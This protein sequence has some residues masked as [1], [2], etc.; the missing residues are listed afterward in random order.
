M[1]PEGPHQPLKLERLD[2]GVA[3]VMRAQ[4]RNQHIL[5]LNVHITKDAKD[6]YCH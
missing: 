4:I 1:K 3:N 6:R 2:L 5:V